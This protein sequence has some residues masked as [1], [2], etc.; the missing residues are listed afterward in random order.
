ML[1]ACETIAWNPE[2]ADWNPARYETQAVSCT[3][4]ASTQGIEALAADPTRIS[5]A[6]Q[7]S[8]GVVWGISPGFSPQ[9]YTWH[10]SGWSA[11]T[12]SEPEIAGMTP[13][14]IWNGPDGGVLLLYR[15][16]GR[17]ILIWRRAT[18]RKML[19]QPSSSNQ[20]ELPESF[21][22]ESVAT[23]PG[24][25]IVVATD[26]GD[27]YR[28]GVRVHAGQQLLYRLDAEG[29]LHL[30]YTVSPD[31]YVT[32]TAP[33]GSTGFVSM[34]A[35]NTVLGPDGKIWLWS[36]F[37]PLGG[38][39]KALDGFLITDGKTVDLRRIASL[40]TQY[41]QDLAPWDKEHLAAAD[42]G[43]GLY[44]IDTRTLQVQ[45]MPEP[46]PGA[47][48]FVEKIVSSRGDHY[49]LTSSGVS[50]I[51]GIF[52]GNLWRLR[53]GRWEKLLDHADALSITALA[54]PKG[55][56]VATVG[57]G[58]WF[59]PA[60]GK[61][62]RFAWNNGLSL[63]G[64]NRMFRLSDGKILAID[65]LDSTRS[66]AFDR[67]ELAAQNTAGS[68]FSVLYP[69]RDM[70]PASKGHLWALLRPRRLSEWNGAEWTQHP[71]P[72]DVQLPRITGLGIDTTG[73]VWLFPNCRMGPVGVF[74]SRANSWVTYDDYRLA[75]TRQTEPVEFLNPDFTP[76][77]P[78]YG[79]NSQIVFVGPCS[80]VNYFDGSQWRLW[81]NNQLPDASYRNLNLLPFFDRAGKLAMDIRNNTW[82]WD[83]ER[84]VNTAFEPQQPHLDP[85]FQIMIS[86]SP[87]KDSLGRSWWVRDDSLYESNGSDTRMVLPCSEAQPFID[88][89]RL[90][91]VL[92]DER[93][94]AFL[95]TQSPFSYV[96]VRSSAYSPT[97]RRGGR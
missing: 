6:A 26:G 93:G 91:R 49:L 69:L 70:Q 3:Q 41:L 4:P 1:D 14:G 67:H 58:L 61:P 54:T 78:I 62:Q 80:G 88:G 18:G 8:T 16:T 83:G 56:W 68:E 21:T 71:L 81:R 86:R 52:T 2:A 97:F 30:I 46:E 89:R 87:V 35:L 92:L 96:I 31:Q 53:D 43:Q 45:Q 27:I 60:S 75:L 37:S 76:M 42:F 28:D 12:S 48:R 47:F 79:P 44:T 94:N 57:R 85:L 33:S 59:I 11:A 19:T 17:R 13:A 32:H 82:E 84:W 65:T 7:D 90:V 63:G 36:H 29:N 50:F 23:A 74:E 39:A 9:V 73:R 10:D 72:D 95:E 38:N 24:G 51:E 55:L 77:R 34:A 40:S 15:G 20:E 66:I 5:Q 22:V 64:A 25:A